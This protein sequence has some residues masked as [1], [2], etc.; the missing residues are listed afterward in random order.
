MSHKISTFFK[1]TKWLKSAILNT[2]IYSG[3]IRNNIF[4]E[5][6]MTFD[7]HMSILD[8]CDAK[9]SNKNNTPLLFKKNKIATRYN[10]EF[11]CKIS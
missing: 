6:V 9:K 8:N 4:D 7:I 10:M 3:D 5:G 1:N 11:V 2:Y